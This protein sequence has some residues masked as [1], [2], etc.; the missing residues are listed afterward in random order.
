MI[1]KNLALIS[2]FLLIFRFSFFVDL[3]PFGMKHYI[4][5]K[6]CEISEFALNKVTETY[7]NLV[8]NLSF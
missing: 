2:E 6:I 4:V 7:L 5:H 3:A 8:A 1:R